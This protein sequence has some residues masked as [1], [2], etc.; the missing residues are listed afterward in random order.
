M[1]L[2]SIV[3]AKNFSSSSL[4]K[5]LNKPNVRG[6]LFQPNLTLASKAT[7]NPF[8]GSRLTLDQDGKA[9]LGQPI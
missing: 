2:T 5:K 3:N 1:T 8:R 7:A 9:C 4:T 6:K